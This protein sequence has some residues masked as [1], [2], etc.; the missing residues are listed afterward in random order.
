M[1]L[2]EI[3]FLQKREVELENERVFLRTKIAEL[4][5]IQ[6]SNMIVSTGLNTIQAMASHDFFPLNMIE[7]GTSCS[8]PDKKLLHLG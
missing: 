8:Q 4:E 5:R 3:E 6:P 1:L 7:D 2:A